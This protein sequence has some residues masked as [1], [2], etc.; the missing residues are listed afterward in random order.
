L[1]VLSQLEQWVQGSADGIRQPD[2]TIWFELDPVIA[3]E[4]LAGARVPDRFESQP[5]AFF[6]QVHLGYAKRADAD[7]ARFARID[8]SKTKH[9]VWQQ[10]TRAL[11]QKGWLSIMVATPAGLE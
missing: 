9:A 5:V 1:A 8:A 11:V 4:R 10:I 2:L 6:E 3:A 7:P